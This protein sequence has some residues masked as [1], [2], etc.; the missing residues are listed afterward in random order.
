MSNITNEYDQLD[1]EE[2][3]YC[4]SD[5]NILTKNNNSWLKTSSKPQENEETKLISHKSKSGIER[6]NKQDILQS[7]NNK[8]K[9]KGK[10][11]GKNNKEKKQ[12]DKPK[13]TKFVN[14]EDFL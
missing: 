2:Y 4:K 1:Y 10:N 11:K 14:L 5:N 13:K 6:N 9:N 8:C 7:G 3:N 12:E